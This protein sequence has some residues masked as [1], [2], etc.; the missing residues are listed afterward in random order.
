MKNAWGLL[1]GASLLT[2]CGN[3]V[4]TPVQGQGSSASSLLGDSGSF[5]WSG[6]GNGPSTSLGEYLCP[7]EAN[8]KPAY[9]WGAP[10]DGLYTAC[11]SRDSV[12]RIHLS[13]APRNAGQRVCFFPAQVIDPTDSSQPTRILAKPGT[14]GLPMATCG[15]PGTIGLNLEFQYTVFNAGFVVDE[16][17]LAQMRNCLLTSQSWQ[18]PRDWSFGRFRK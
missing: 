8:I 5:T 2:G 1:L 3:A 15:Y 13:G 7:A 6:T 17:D 9:Q 4:M 10:T 11:P 16:A 14:D 18:C 12:N